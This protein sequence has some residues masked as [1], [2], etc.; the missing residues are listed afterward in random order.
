[1]RK[2][3]QITPYRNSCQLDLFDWERQMRC[4]IRPSKSA[5]I[6]SKRTGVSL[7]VAGLYADLNGMG[8]V[9]D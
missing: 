3:Y 5:V 2:L 1:M 8:G 4:H 9:D 7:P 6:L